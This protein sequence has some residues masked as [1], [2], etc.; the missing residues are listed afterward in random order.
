MRIIGEGGV[1]GLSSGGAS[2]LPTS[3]PHTPYL[4][5]NEETQSAEQKRNKQSNKNDAPRKPITTPKKKM[6][7]RIL[8]LFRK[9]EAVAGNNRL[10]AFTLRIHA[11]L[12]ANE[13]TPANYMGRII[14]RRLKEFLGRKV[15]F[16]AVM[17]WRTDGAGDLH[18]H[19]CI[20][21]APDEE[22][23]ASEALCAAGGPWRDKQGKARQVDI[24]PID[25][26][27]SFKGQFGLAG[28]S[29]YCADDTRQT[30]IELDRRRAALDPQHRYERAANIILKSGFQNR[31]PYDAVSHK[32][33]RMPYSLTGKRQDRKSYAPVS[34]TTESKPYDG[35]DELVA[36]SQTE[37][38]NEYRRRLIAERDALRLE[39]ADLNRRL[40]EATDT[41]ASP[42]LLDQLT[43]EHRAAL[44]AL[45]AE[46]RAALEAVLERKAQKMKDIP[47]PTLPP[48]PPPAE[49]T[50]APDL[51]AIAAD[52]SMEFEDMP[53]VGEVV[54]EAAVIEPINEDE[55]RRDALHNKREAEQAAPPVDDSH[56]SPAE[57][58]ICAE[59]DAI[60][61]QA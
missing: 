17:E 28:W 16:V 21:L 8:G 51:D 50:T 7:A 26:A 39:V 20:L 31:E 27:K 42:S 60:V 6:A 53:E 19:G 49:E 15:K 48:D 25:D 10:Y 40:A 4:N 47:A 32:P 45:L 9:V 24:R 11:P 2:Y 30:E 57:R 52:F 13:P 61:A 1:E 41:P 29:A 34:H 58:A 56:L 43:P 5:D 18:L 55:K 46:N 33:V 38:T 14:A 35:K 23:R 54:E 37:R 22:R 59:L 36:K 12:L 44:E 3:Q